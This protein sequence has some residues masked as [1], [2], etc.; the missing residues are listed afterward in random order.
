M[1]DSYVFNFDIDD[2]IC[3]MS[4]L[5]GDV[6]IRD[7]YL[8]LLMN[9]NPIDPYS[10]EY[11]Y[12]WQKR[13][14]YLKRKTDRE[15]SNINSFIKI[16]EDN[17]I[18][19]AFFNFVKFCNTRNIK[20]T[21]ILRGGNDNI[22]SIMPFIEDKIM[23][24]TVSLKDI[25]IECINETILVSNSITIESSKNKKFPLSNSNN[26]Y[27]FTSNKSNIL[28]SNNDLTNKVLEVRYSDTLLNETLFTDL[29]FP[30]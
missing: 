16:L 14:A 10:R 24:E 3:N 25:P 29:L 19:P 13:Q 20:Y 8:D 21:L 17:P 6:I 4:F 11:E 23:F 30:K 27:Y 2:V 7:W 28:C 12:G 22:Y 15:I 18:S 9:N 26:E 1:T 5:N